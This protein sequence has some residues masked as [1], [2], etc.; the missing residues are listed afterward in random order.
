MVNAMTPQEEKHL[1]EYNAMT[2]KQLQDD[3]KVRRPSGPDIAGL[4]WCMEAQDVE[5]VGELHLD[6]GVM[7]SLIERFPDDDQIQQGA[8]CF[9]RTAINKIDN[10]IEDI[11]YERE[12]AEEFTRI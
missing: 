8:Q 9:I 2:E 12:R 1:Q 7:R 10:L 5:Y 3:A 6:I 11:K 4:Y